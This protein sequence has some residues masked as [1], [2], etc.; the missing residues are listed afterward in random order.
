MVVAGG[1][2]RIAAWMVA[3][4]CG[5]VTVGLVVVVVVY[6]LDTGDRTASVVGAVAGLAGLAVSV[7]FGLRQQGGRGAVVR[8]SGRGAIAV[9]G[10]VVGNALGDRSKVTGRPS[11]P[12]RSAA[13]SSD[14]EVAAHGNGAF[15]SDGDV[16]GNAFG[17]GSEVDGR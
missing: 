3:A 6:D 11:L 17:E 14:A 7:Y 16:V 1:A 8:A 10:S 9:R 12:V 4:L 2:A 5:T 13:T 15:A